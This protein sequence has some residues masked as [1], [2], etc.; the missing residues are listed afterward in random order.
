MISLISLGANAVQIVSAIYKNGYVIIQKI[1]K[2]IEEWMDHKNFSTIE[3]FRGRLSTDPEK[4]N[5]PFG[6][7]QYVRMFEEKTPLIAV[8]EIDS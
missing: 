2:E 5:N 8:H 7:F 6:R 3:G 1:S 4:R